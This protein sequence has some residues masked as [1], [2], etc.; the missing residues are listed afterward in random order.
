VMNPRSTDIGVAMKQ[1]LAC[2]PLARSNQWQRFPGVRRMQHSV[3]P[4]QAGI[5]RR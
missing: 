2:W 1:R 5:Q 3:V 4:A